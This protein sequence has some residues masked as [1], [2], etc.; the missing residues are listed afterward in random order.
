MAVLLL[1]A[2]GRTSK[3]LVAVRMVN[4]FAKKCVLIMVEV[5]DPISKNGDLLIS[6]T[7]VLFGSSFTLAYTQGRIGPPSTKECLA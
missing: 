1:R 7:I 3:R 6:N 2:A 5:R 4:A